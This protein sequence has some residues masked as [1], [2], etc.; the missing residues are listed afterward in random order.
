MQP[1]AVIHRR[2]NEKETRK[3]KQQL[4]KKTNR[5]KTDKTKKQQQNKTK[6]S[7]QTSLVCFF[8]F[9]FVCFLMNLRDTCYGYVSTAVLARSRSAIQLQNSC[10]IRRCF[11]FVHLLDSVEN[12]RERIC[13]FLFMVHVQHR[14]IMRIVVP[15]VGVTNC[16]IV[17]IWL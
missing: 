14:C 16:F 17:F 2:I 1:C 4:N 3:K 11:F 13:L 5:N 9:V 12:S 15:C 7:L 8:V 6:N 10:K